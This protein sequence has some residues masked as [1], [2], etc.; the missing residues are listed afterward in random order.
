MKINIRD[1]SPSAQNDK[2]KNQN[3]KIKKDDKI[4]RDDKIKE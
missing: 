2:I 1:S 3:D 4:K